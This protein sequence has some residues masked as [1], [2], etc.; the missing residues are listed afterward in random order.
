MS[1]TS[2]AH[3]P[4]LN[5]RPKKEN[6]MDLQLKNKVAIV[7]GAGWGIGKATAVGLADEGVSV[8]IADLDEGRGATAA[9]EIQ[10]KSQEALFVKTDVADWASVEFLVAATLKKYGQI[11]ILVNVAGAWRINFFTKMPRE[12]WDLEIK[13]NY[14][15]TLNCSKAVIEHMISRKTGSIIHVASDAGRVGEP[16]QPVYS[17][18]KAAVIGFGK[19]LAKEVGRNNIRVNTVCPSMTVGERRLQM[20]EKMRAEEPERYAKYRAQMDGL[21]KLYPMR[22]FGKPEDVANMIVFLASDLRAGHITG[23]TF[24][25]NGGYCMV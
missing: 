3:S 12:D 22:K 18:V 14:C 6:N 19:A 25:V 13:V 16:N 15:G 11:D 21:R 17:G 5:F 4:R 20:E 2:L 24:S 9:R 10:D 8:V 7:T 1:A 23:Q